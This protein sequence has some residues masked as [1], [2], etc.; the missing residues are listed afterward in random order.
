MPALSAV[1]PAAIAI[2]WR[3]EE[4]EE[5]EEEEDDDDDGDLPFAPR[6]FVGGRVRLG[7]GSSMTLA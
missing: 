7:M 6:R 1:A 2:E 3:R 5:E 4:E